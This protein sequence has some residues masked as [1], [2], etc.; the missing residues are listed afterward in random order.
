MEAFG[1]I[2]CNADVK[3]A[4]WLAGEDVNEAAW[5]DVMLVLL[6]CRVIRGADAPRMGGR[7]KPGHGELEGG[8][9]SGQARGQEPGHGEGGGASGLAQRLD[10]MAEIRRAAS[11]GRATHPSLH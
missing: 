11:K 10:G 4:V 6:R 9:S 2:G 5:H 1:K 3:S 7:V 8:S